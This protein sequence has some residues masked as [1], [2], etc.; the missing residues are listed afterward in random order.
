MRSTAEICLFMNLDDKM[1]VRKFQMLELMIDA[2]NANVP[3]KKVSFN[4]NSQS[5]KKAFEHL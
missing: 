1:E 2:I 3:F 5:G 4:K